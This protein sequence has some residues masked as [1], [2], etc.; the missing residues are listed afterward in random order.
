MTWL[1]TKLREVKHQPKYGAQR[2]ANIF[3][4]FMILVPHLIGSAF[5]FQHTHTFAAVFVVIVTVH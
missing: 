2:Q 5:V 3:T 1:Q 4:S